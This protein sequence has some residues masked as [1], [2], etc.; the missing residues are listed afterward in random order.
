MCKQPGKG[1]LLTKTQEDAG[2]T[3]G[4]APR[5]GAGHQMMGR[6]C[7]RVRA[8][9]PN[10]SLAGHALTPARCSSKPSSLGNC[11]PRQSVSPK[12]FPGQRYAGTGW[13]G[14]PSGC[15]RL[16][17]GCTTVPSVTLVTSATPAQDNQFFG[18]YS[19][20]IQWIQ[21]LTGRRC[22]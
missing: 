22:G 11:S 21:P 2:Q 3:C 13:M 8:R 15:S 10:A 12:T 19:E 20:Q 5:C 4:Q 14:T 1:H 6:R 7:C 9:S 18:P 16:V 17:L